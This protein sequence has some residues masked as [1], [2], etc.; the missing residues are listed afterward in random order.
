MS[1]ITIDRDYV[2]RQYELLESQQTGYTGHPL[3]RGLDPLV[4]A[5]CDG[6][7][8]AVVDMIVNRADVVIR[9]MVSTMTVEQMQTLVEWL[10]NA[11]QERK[12]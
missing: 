12:T 7:E 3:P 9:T 11:L 5:M 4:H 8:R 10:M 1:V 2:I 6:V